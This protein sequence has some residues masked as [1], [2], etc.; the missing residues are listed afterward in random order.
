MNLNGS[1]GVNKFKKSSYNFSN[2]TQQSL[3]D[4]F[5]SDTISENKYRLKA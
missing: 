2:R 1:L 4:K 3:M 5:D